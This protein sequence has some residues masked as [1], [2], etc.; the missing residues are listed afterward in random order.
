MGAGCE[1]TG[2]PPQY[3]HTGGGKM[4]TV[5]LASLEPRKLKLNLGS[6]FLKETQLLLTAELEMQ[7]RVQKRDATLCR[8]SA[9]PIPVLLEMLLQL[10]YLPLPMRDATL[11][12]SR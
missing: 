10:V 6:P 12:R 4:P 11:C 9:A 3:L 2:G 8:R 7:L 5:C 1:Q